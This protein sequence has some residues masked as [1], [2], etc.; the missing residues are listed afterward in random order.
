MSTYDDT[1]LV[2][3]F[4]A[5]APEPLPGDWGD[6]VDRVGKARP[7]RRRLPALPRRRGLVVVLAA[8]AAVAVISATALAV[9]AYF[10]ESGFIGIP[11]AGATASTPET[12]R[13]VLTA[14][15]VARRSRTQMWLYADGRL[16]WRR[17]SPRGSD[18]AAG[19]NRRFTGFLEQRLTKRGVAMLRSEVLATGLVG[20]GLALSLDDQPCWN[21]IDVRQADRFIG[22]RWHG[23]HCLAEPGGVKGTR[24]ATREQ[25][26]ALLRLMERLAYPGSWL[27]AMGWS[28]RRIRA[29]VPAEFEVWYGAW[30]RD[31]G[32]SHVLRPLPAPARKLL[33]AA[34]PRR[35]QVRSGP[36]QGVL[37][38]T[39][40]FTFRLSTDDARALRLVLSARFD[41]DWA[42]EDYALAY[43]VRARGPGGGP[44]LLEFDPILP[45]GEPAGVGG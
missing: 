21:G 43:R 20:R 41:V 37:V 29:Y 2:A 33:R 5:L 40:I 6:I 27:P 44:V 25:A 15:G 18:L 13:L 11:P 28:D 35:W 4:A 8:I 38:P 39:S 7:R 14:Y 3:R 22:V 19:A 30:P 31:V 24:P 17:E 1:L 26:R 12:G 42:T 45:H 34:E 16:I 10:I 23:S 32:L 36:V 9:R